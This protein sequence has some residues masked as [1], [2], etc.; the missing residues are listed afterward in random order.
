MEHM[1]PAAASLTSLMF[2]LPHSANVNSRHFLCRL[3]ACAVP[4]VKLESE[5]STRIR[6]M[7]MHQ[8]NNIRSNYIPASV[9][10]LK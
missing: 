3:I 6:R 4:I 10:K 9:R 8:A 1:H 7:G 5:L 2:S